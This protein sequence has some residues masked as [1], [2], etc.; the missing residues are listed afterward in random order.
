VTLETFANF[1]EVFGG[2]AVLV[3]LLYAILEIRRNTRAV[4]ASSAWSSDVSLAELNEGIAHNAQLSELVTRAME[5]E[6]RPE[7]LSP[8]EFGQL[9]VLYRAVLQKYQAQWFLWTEGHLPDEMW[10]N[11]RRWARSF[12]ALPVPARIWELETNQH[13]YAAGFVE[14]INSMEAD[15]N[16]SFRA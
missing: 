5:A 16:L 6:T 1:A 12:V 14:S 4:R 10:Q 11:R 15:S 9:F 8:A 3:S 2:L 13:Q 7:D